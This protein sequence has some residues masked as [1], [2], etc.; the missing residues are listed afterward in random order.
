MLTDK[1][2]GWKKL[3]AGLTKLNGKEAK[4]GLHADAVYPDGK[5]VAHIGVINEFGAGAIPQRSFMRSTFDENE[6]NWAKEFGNLVKNGS[7]TSINKVGII[8]A[9]GIVN[10]I[11]TGNFVPNA[12]STIAQK[13]SS[14]PLIDTSQM[15]VSIKSV[16]GK[17]G[18]R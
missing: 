8:A 13:G 11:Y 17:R 16:V 10:K 7:T 5:Q 1:D 4:V 3:I 2:K 15:V 9:K 6:N 18:N 14:K 12:P